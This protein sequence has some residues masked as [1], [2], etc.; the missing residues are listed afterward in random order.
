[1]NF[2]INIITDNDSFHSDVQRQIKWIIDRAMT[3][4]AKEINNGN[5]PIEIMLRDDNGN[6]VGKLTYK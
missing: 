5:N 6:N 3:K 1:M 4:F 2:K